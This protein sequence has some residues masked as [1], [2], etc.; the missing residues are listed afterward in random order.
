MLVPVYCKVE[1][2]TVQSKGHLSRETAQQLLHELAGALRENVE[3]HRPD[4]EPAPST[5]TE[6]V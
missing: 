6:N 4:S 1:K 2:K 5:R 3:A